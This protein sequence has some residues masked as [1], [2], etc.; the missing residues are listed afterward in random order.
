MSGAD[1]KVMPI[2]GGLRY[3]S[4]VNRKRWWFLLKASEEVLELLESNWDPVQIQTSWKLEQC[5]KP[6]EY[7]EH[8]SLLDQAQ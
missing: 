7:P 1:N 8:S 5:T 2:I 4:E 6:T 3:R